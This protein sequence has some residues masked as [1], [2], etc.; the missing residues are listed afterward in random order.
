MFKEKDFSDIKIEAGKG[1]PKR[2]RS[3]K[4]VSNSGAL[5]CSAS[6]SEQFVGLEDRIQDN[7]THGG[8]LVFQS[9]TKELSW[10]RG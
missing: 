6:D 10:Q 7:G 2:L 8:C 9:T 1:N 5:L 4:L 3:V